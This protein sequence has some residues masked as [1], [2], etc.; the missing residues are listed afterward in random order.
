MKITVLM[1]NESCRE[2]LLFEHG[3]SFLVEADGRRSMM[4]TGASDAFLINAQTL[5]VD[6]TQLD[7]VLISHNHNDHTGGIRQMAEHNPSVSFYFKEAAHNRLYQISPEPRIYPGEQVGLKERYIGEPEGFFDRMAKRIVWV[8]E[9]LQLSKRLYL[10]SATHLD[11]RF[12]C[13]DQTLCQ[14]KEGEMIPDDFSHEMFL[15]E[16]TSQGLI[17]LS[18][19]SHNGILNIAQSAMEQ[20]HQPIRYLV[21]G[22][23]LGGASRLVCTPEFVAET[24]RRLMELGCEKIYTCHCTGRLAFGMLQEEMGDRLAYLKTGDVLCLGE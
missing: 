13:Q 7:G 16:T 1:E 2:D 5:G 23:H 22:F 19:C 18:S 20:F 21:G 6:L 10:C 11:H 8:K 3:L 12:S 24:G 15:V 9:G 4:D 17:L 14:L